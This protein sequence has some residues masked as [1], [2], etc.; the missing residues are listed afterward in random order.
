M[1][2]DEVDEARRAVVAATDAAAAAQ[3]A[4][5]EAGARHAAHPSGSDRRPLTLELAAREHAVANAAE[6]LKRAEAEQEE[7]AAKLAELDA[8]L[9]KVRRRVHSN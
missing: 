5:D 7:L 1:L 8:Q 4:M 3:L 2:K 6:A 9:A